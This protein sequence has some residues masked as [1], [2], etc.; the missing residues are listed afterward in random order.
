MANVWVFPLA[1]GGCYLWTAAASAQPSSGRELLD[2]VTQAHRAS[3][4]LIHTTSCR[5]EFQVAIKNSRSNSTIRQ[6]CS[7]KYWSSVDAIRL[8]VSDQNSNNPLGD[9]R[10]DLDY[11]WKDSVRKLVHRK[12][13]SAGKQLVGAGRDGYENRY[14]HR[15]DAWARGLLVLNVPGTINCLPFERLVEKATRLKRAEWK[16]VE[17]NKLAMIELVIPQANSPA[18]SWD[19]QFYFDPNVNYLVRKE[20]YSLGSYVREQEVVQF[21]ESAPGLFFP[22]QVSGRS[23]DSTSSTL[24]SEIRVNQPLP[25]GVFNFRYP[26]GVYLSDGIKG[27]S[28]RVDI[29]GNPISAATP[30]ARGPLPPR[31]DAESST[32]RTETEEEPRSLTRWILPFALVILASAGVVAVI[33]R[34]RARTSTA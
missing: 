10:E 31:S 1:I 3:R 5:V 34:W 24:L 18:D 16:T 26:H 19:V 20:V 9:L 11:C 25:A 7:G 14:L 15:C 32:L 13:D 4:E 21:K 22:E 12:S 8:E 2:F 28:Y 17:G 6:S 23:K 29:E 33:R 30:H 27:V